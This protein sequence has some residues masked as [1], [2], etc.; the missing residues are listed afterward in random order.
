VS[1]RIVLG[2]VGAVVG[3]YVGGPVGALQGFALGYGVGGAFEKQPGVDGPRLQDLRFQG[4]N[5]GGI[6]PIIFG[7]MR[8]SGNI[9]WAAELKEV[10]STEEVGGKGGGQDVTTYSY[11]G[12]FAISLC[13]GPAN[14]VRRIWADGNLI[15]DASP[16]AP[17]SG[18]APFKFYA[19]SES[20]SPDPTMEAYLG[21]GNVPAYRGQA[22]V[23]FSDFALG[24][25]GNRIPQLSFEVVTNAVRTQRAIEIGTV[26]ETDHAWTF[27]N[28]SLYATTSSSGQINQFDP[29]TGTRIGVAGNAQA[30]SFSAVASDGR[31]WVYGRQGGQT[32]EL[33]HS[34]GQARTIDG[35]RN[36]SSP[37][38][39]GDFLFAIEEGSGGSA[40]INKISSRSETVVAKSQFNVTGGAGSMV[41]DGTYLFWTNTLRTLKIE[42]RTMQTAISNEWP[43]GQYIDVQFYRG[44]LYLSKVASVQGVGSSTVEVRSPI[45]F[46]VIV[47]P[48][49]IGIGSA[50]IIPTGNNSILVTSNFFNASVSE[51]D[52]DTLGYMGTFNDVTGGFGPG[53]PSVSEYILADGRILKRQPPYPGTSGP[54]RLFDLRTGIMETSPVSLSALVQA[55]CARAG[56]SPAEIDSTELADGCDGYVLNNPSSAR[57]DL[58]PLM[59]AYF[60]DAI[61][62]DGKIKF[63]KRARPMV[64]TIPDDD[65]AATENEGEFPP[66]VQTTRLQEAELPGRFNVSYMAQSLDYQTG[67]QMAM[68]MTGGSKDIAN[69]ELPISMSDAKAKQVADGLLFMAWNERTRHTIRLPRKYGDLEPCDV[70]RAGGFEMRIGKKEELGNGIITLECTSNFGEVY[71]QTGAAGTSLSAGGQTVLLP[72]PSQVQFLDI[73]LLRDQDDQSGYYVAASGFFAGWPGVALYKSLD[74]GA[75][76]DGVMS[77][78]AQAVM[79]NAETV[80]GNFDARNNI[81]DEQNLVRVRVY[82]INATLASTTELNVLNGAN[83][84]MLG[85][86][87]IQFKNAVLQADG[88]YL[89]TG[90][91][92]G[93]LGTEWAIGTHAVGERF[94]LLSTATIRNRFDPASDINVARYYKSV[95]AGQPLSTGSVQTFMN[96]AVRL[97]CYAPT[98]IGGGRDATGNLTINWK[99]RTR[100]DGNWR[101]A[102][103]VPLGET[104]ETYEI[105]VMQGATIKRTISGLTTP[106]TIYTSAQQIADFGANQVSVSVRVYQLSATVGRGYPGAATV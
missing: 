105:D 106:T 97:K 49:M 19:G 103:D 87:L 46:S 67:T 15:Y 88:S 99:R 104:S 42:M 38:V 85:S 73:P 39:S 100:R 70:I 35:V 76:Y 50:Y 83:A 52:A 96:S 57:V 63:R 95:T 56:L 59:A 86:E 45:D 40:W 71:T 4:S 47:P 75:I 65:L 77:W 34:N 92:R 7:T 48:Q 6:I 14:A 102:V 98:D 93:R 58:E 37:I 74:A 17:A 79:G 30:G 33:V 55:L 41:S 16:S 51:Y 23:V 43:S 78:S 82:G 84:A 29:Y 5:Y 36:L 68:R 81:F 53:A 20:Q 44:R 27:A 66:A 9:I 61:E 12:N 21:A 80:L 91:L 25:Y 94:V 1:T 13:E 54:V 101:D 72:S 64:V 26:S 3:F 11:Y 8:V 62:S 60:F 31:F 32:L 22:Y 69:L 28:G 90:F 2:A 18:R 10:S 89:L 24:R